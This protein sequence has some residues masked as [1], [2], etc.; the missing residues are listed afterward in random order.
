MPL[1]SYITKPDF[2]RQIKQYSGTTATLSGITNILEQFLVKSIEIDTAGALFGDVL[3]FDGVKFLP[4]VSGGLGNGILSGMILSYNTGLTYNVSSGTYRFNGII[5]NY[6][7]GSVTIPSGDPT[8]SRFDVVYVT[9]DSLSNTYVLTGT[10]TNNPTIPTLTVNQLQVGIISVPAN[11]T[12]GTGSTTIQVTSDTVFEFY[13]NGAGTGIQRAGAGGNAQAPGDFSFAPSRDSRAFADDSIA[14]GRG[15]QASGVSQ[16]VVGQHNVPNTTDFFIVGYGANSGAK[17]NAFSVNNSGNTFVSNKLFVTSIEVETTGAS[18]NFALIYDSV[19]NKFKPQSILTT[20]GGITG[21]TSAGTGNILLLSTVTNNTLVYKSISAGTNISISENNGTVVFNN[22]FTGITTATSLDNGVKVL[23]SSNTTN[24]A[25]STLSSQTPNL[26]RI[27]S[28]PTGLIVFSAATPPESS[29]I[30]TGTS[31]GNGVRLLFSSNTTTLSFSTLSSQTPSLLNIISS[32]TGVILFSA[33]TPPSS[34]GITTATSLGG[35]VRLLFSSDTSNLAFATLSSQT[36]STL[37]IISSSTGL[38]LFSAITSGGS[39]VTLTSAGTGNALLISSV[40]NNNIVQKSISAGTKT[41]VTDDGNGTITIATQEEVTGGQARNLALYRTSAAIVYSSFTDGASIEG[42]NIRLASHT[43]STGRTYTV[44]DVSNN[45]DFVMTQGYQIIN[46]KKEFISGYTVGPLTSSSSN[47]IDNVYN[48]QYT[49]KS[50][51]IQTYNDSQGNK[52]DILNLT[53]SLKKLYNIRTT[54]EVLST[55]GT[56]VGLYE[57][58]QIK[59]SG[60]TDNDGST[61]LSGTVIANAINYRS[62]IKP[63]NFVGGAHFISNASYSIPAITNVV[64][65]YYEFNIKGAN[66]THFPH[67]IN[68]YRGISLAGYAGGAGTEDAEVTEFYDIYVG[69]VLRPTGSNP[70]VTINRAAGLYIEKKDKSTDPNKDIPSYDVLKRNLFNSADAKSVFYTNTPWSLFAEA[71]RAYIGNT[72]VLA[73]ALTLTSVTR[74]AW[75]DIGP[76]QATKPHINFSSGTAPTSPQIG[77]LWWNGTQ[78]YFRKD[79]STNVD[80]LSNTSGGT[81]GIT[82]GQNVGSGVQ[83][84]LSSGTGNLYFRTLSSATPSQLSITQSGNLVI[85]SSN[86]SGGSNVTLSSAGTG[87]RLLISS[88]TNNNIIQKSISAGTG[89]QITESNG[90]LIFVSTA[91]GGTGSTLSGDYLPLSGG[92]VSGN[93]L[94][95]NTIGDKGILISNSA[96]TFQESS[97]TA[98]VTLKTDRLLFTTNVDVNILDTLPSGYMVIAPS[99]SGESGKYIRVNSNNISWEYADLS[100]EFLAL[101][102]GTVSGETIFLS[103]ISATSIYNDYI[104]FNT[105]ATVTSQIGRLNWNDTDGTLQLGLKGGVVKS[106]LGQGLVTRV[107]NKTVP[108]INLSASTYNVVVVAGATGQRLSVKLAQANNDANSAG[109]LGVVAEDIASNQEGY[110]IT[111]GLLK[112]IN[113]TGSLQGESWNDGDILYLSPTIAGQLTKNKPQA[114]NHTVIIGY[115]EYK[116]INQGKI[117]VKIDNGYELDELHNVRITSPSNYNILTYDAVTYSSWTNTTLNEALSKTLLTANIPVTSQVAQVNTFYLYDKITITSASASVTVTGISANTSISAYTPSI[118]FFAQT[119][120]TVTFRNS[121][122]LKTEG[123]LDAV[124][125]GSTYDSITFTYNNEIGRYFQTNI[126]NYI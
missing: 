81:S 65:Q 51:T 36:P 8:F 37:R 118:K 68:S 53:H 48:L 28:T 10:A 39:N 15:I 76:S 13:S 55:G 115:V 108:L 109:T 5:Y 121:T 83:V 30:T 84:Y 87:N 117:Y 110:V 6:T 88:V 19:N 116:H 69:R 126:N 60:G 11:F 62:S 82:D 102:G 25:F 78:L 106:Q 54:E 58:Y 74:G 101:T 67:L 105:G 95:S 85:F 21:I 125:S 80:L 57:E 3:G 32:S 99:P 124:I 103:G 89:M 1:D 90:T 29:G 100:T 52:L 24:L 50:E 35:G 113:T 123:G 33:A 97:G 34:S 23:F 45:A 47:F 22:T 77:D 64:N 49:N 86:T 122:T 26:L 70:S 2:S 93:T 31:L 114:P 42:L 73:S 120:V 12:G 111:V 107:V 20:T 4:S 112:D 91:T 75:L 38:I 104:D 44:P 43:S 66:T 92:T 18:N 96:I 63:N 16:T 27:T 59:R 79:A 98:N 119:G 14:L 17:A 71:D 94:F 61:N 72:L 7:G 46:G 9:G 41:S 40:T 56:N